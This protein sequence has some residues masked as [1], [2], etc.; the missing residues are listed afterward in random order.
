MID[1]GATDTYIALGSNLADPLQ[2]VTTALAELSD[3]A[4]TRLLASSPWYRSRA[5]GPGSQP[6]YING[7]AHLR[8]RL[9]PQALLLALQA[10]EQQHRRVRTQHW[11]PRTLDLD[12]LLYGSQQIHSDTLQ[13][14]HPRLAERNFVL[15]P[16][17]DLGGDLTLP[18][19][20]SVESLLA[21]CA[22]DGL[23][24]LDN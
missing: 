19:G 18:N 15:Y 9:A 23:R 20:V 17:A 21:K 4:Q 2:Q 8:T 3:L 1:D 14:P 7:V 13:I 6:D 16:L 10:I 22:A 5:V 11:G 12:I 24:R